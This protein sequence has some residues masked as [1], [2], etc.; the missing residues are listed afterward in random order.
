M[1]NGTRSFL[2]N[3]LDYLEEKFTIYL[4]AKQGIEKRH[5]EQR[6]TGKS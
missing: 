1:T 3:N 4:E 2:K 6:G 5:N